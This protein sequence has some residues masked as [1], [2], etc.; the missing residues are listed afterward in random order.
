[1]RIFKV[2]S[3][4]VFVLL[5]VLLAV[6]VGLGILGS[7]TEIDA[8]GDVVNVYKPWAD[9]LQPAGKWLGLAAPWVYPFMAWVP[10]LLAKAI[11]FVDYLN[12]WMLLAGALLA[13]LLTGAVAAT[14]SPRR[15]REQ[16]LLRARGIAVR[17][18]HDQYVVHTEDLGPWHHGDRAKDYPDLGIPR[19]TVR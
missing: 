9:A 16:A 1:M 10:I 6:Q 3:T 8:V 15:R 13:G 4:N 19:S 12:S 2:F 17:F 11:G 18:E 7:T 5:S 14:D